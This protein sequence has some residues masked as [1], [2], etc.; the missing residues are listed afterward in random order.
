MDNEDDL[1]FFILFFVENYT[2]SLR[3]LT[4]AQILT[5]FK[6]LQA[7]MSKGSFCLLSS[8]K[9]VARQTFFL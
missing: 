5:V 8:D 4:A 3:G 1:L 6:M 2:L 9:C 7:K